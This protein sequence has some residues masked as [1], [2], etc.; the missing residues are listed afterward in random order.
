MTQLGRGGR[1]TRATGEHNQT[2]RHRRK[3]TGRKTRDR[4]NRIAK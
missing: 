3:N 4:E 2:I 1:N